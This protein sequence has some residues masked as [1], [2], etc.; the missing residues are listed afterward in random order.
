[1]NSL[2][3]SRPRFLYLLQV[4]LYLEI[5]QQQS[6]S[7]NLQKPHE[8]IA[9]SLLIDMCWSFDWTHMATIFIRSPEATVYILA[10]FKSPMKNKKKANTFNQNCSEEK[11]VWG[12]AHKQFV[13]REILKKHRR[14]TRVSGTKNLAFN[15]VILMRIP[16]YFLSKSRVLHLVCTPTG[17]YSR[18]GGP[19]SSHVLR[20]QKYIYVDNYEWRWKLCLVLLR[21]FISNKL[22]ECNTEART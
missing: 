7:R 20:F 12:Y 13:T 10:Y 16:P 11:H 4:L 22:F 2:A 18:K 6:S 9:E 8:Y 19:R 1:M 17:V 5:W 3:Q 14:L 15:L 21:N